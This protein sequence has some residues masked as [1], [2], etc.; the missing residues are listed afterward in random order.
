[1]KTE[2]IFIEKR[3]HVLG[4]IKQSEEIMDGVKVR[5]KEISERVRL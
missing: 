1:M 3:E 5:L 2:Q 4:L